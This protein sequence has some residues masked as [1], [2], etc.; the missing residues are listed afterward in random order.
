MNDVIEVDPGERL[1]AQ[2]VIT[3]RLNNFWMLTGAMTAFDVKQILEWLASDEFAETCRLAGA[4]PANV[5]GKFH[6]LIKKGTLENVRNA[7]N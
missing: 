6:D 4:D 2:A 7:I 1:H 5:K 3:E